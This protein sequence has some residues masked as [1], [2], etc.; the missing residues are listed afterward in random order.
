MY[1][2][3]FG[4]LCLLLVSACG[5]NKT[6]TDTTTSSATAP[7]EMGAKI[8]ATGATPLSELIRKMADSTTTWQPVEIDG[9]NTVNGMAAKTEGKVIE[10]CQSAG[11]WLTMKTEDG[12][13]MTVL[14]K[15]HAFKLPKDLAGKTVIA[16]GNAY[17]IVTSVEERRQNAK[18]KGVSQEKIAEITSSTEEYFLSANGVIIKP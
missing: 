4:L 12:K 2:A 18:A 16:E 3:L 8:T 10:V 11:C 15:D 13:E 14:V 1:K 17:K 7:V 6:N 9:G 5:G